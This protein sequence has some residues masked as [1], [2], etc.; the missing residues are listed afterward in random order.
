MPGSNWTH[1]NA[2]KAIIGENTGLQRIFTR[3]DRIWSSAQIKSSTVADAWRM[4]CPDAVTAPNANGQ[5]IKSPATLNKKRLLRRE[6]VA[7]ATSGPSGSWGKRRDAVMAAPV[8][9]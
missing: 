7:A 1:I 9:I 6:R 3:A 5:N 8:P 4:K 2:A